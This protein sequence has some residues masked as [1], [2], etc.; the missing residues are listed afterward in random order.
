MK[1]TNGMDRGQFHDKAW[2]L[3]QSKALDSAL[4]PKLSIHA[5]RTL[6]DVLFDSMTTDAVAPAQSGEP[7]TWRDAIKSYPSPDMTLASQPSQPVEVGE[8]HSRECQ[9]AAC[10]WERSNPEAALDTK[11]LATAQEIALMWGQNHSQF[12]SRIQVAVREAMDWTRA[13]SPQ[14]TVSHVS[15]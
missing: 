3:W 1:P 12:V 9:C 2:A 8:R 11:A 5:I 4:L 6:W 10:N 7:V 15:K 14:A 13:A